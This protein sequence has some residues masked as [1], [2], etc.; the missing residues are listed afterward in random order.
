MAYALS[1][2]NFEA[3]ILTQEGIPH[4]MSYKQKRRDRTK[5]AIIVESGGQ[6]EK[7]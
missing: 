1:L 5:W 3:V 4:G 6:K 2:Y 7:Y